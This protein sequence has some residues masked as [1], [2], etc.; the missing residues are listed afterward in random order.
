MNGQVFIDIAHNSYQEPWQWIDFED[1]PIQM[2]VTLDEP[3]FGFE[4]RRTFDLIFKEA[5][6]ASKSNESYV[7]RFGLNL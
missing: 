3:D 6:R 2:K 1:P 7:E 5:S 4:E